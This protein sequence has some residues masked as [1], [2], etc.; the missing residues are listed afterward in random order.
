MLRLRQ[1]LV[2]EMVAHVVAEHPLEA[3][4][5][6]AGAAEDLP[7]RVIP[8]ANVA[9]SPSFYEV[10]AM[11]LL[12]LHRE[13]EDRGE[14]VVVIYHSH[15]STPA[16]PS[17]TDVALAGEPDAHYVLISTRD[18]GRPEVRSFRIIGAKVTEEEV[19]ISDFVP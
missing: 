3:C 14:R 17:A 19:E 12:R 13:L 10:D 9:A 5:V 16:Y 2:D 6:L 11:E 4:G 8:L 18:P 15:T 1:D 7:A